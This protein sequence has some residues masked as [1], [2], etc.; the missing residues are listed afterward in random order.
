MNNLL[1]SLIHDRP[2]IFKSVLYPATWIAHVALSELV[3]MSFLLF[4]PDFV[5]GYLRLT[6][7]LQPTTKFSCNCF[8]AGVISI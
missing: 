4:L 2:G 5:I 6:Q 8:K 3:A 1:S 7:L